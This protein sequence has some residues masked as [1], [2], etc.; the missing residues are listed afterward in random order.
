M[1]ALAV[2]LCLACDP[3]LPV[4]ANAAEQVDVELVL[5]VDVSRSMDFEE[6]EL[7]RAGYVEAIKDPAF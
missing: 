6:Q 7:Q 2:L 4:G 1:S 3:L 5:A